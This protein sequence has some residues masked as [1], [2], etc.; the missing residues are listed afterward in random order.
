MSHPPRL[1]PS[2][3]VSPR[4]RVARDPAGTLWVQLIRWDPRAVEAL[5]A[6]PGRRWHPDH[7]AWS[8][9]PPPS[10]PAA[11]SALAVSP[12]LEV[13]RRAFPEIPADPS[14]IALVMVGEATASWGSDSVTGAEAAAEPAAGEETQSPGPFPT[15]VE[16]AQRHANPEDEWLVNPK[17]HPDGGLESL[18]L[19]ERREEENARVLER[20]EEELLLAGY[21]GRTRKNYLGYIRRFGEWSP[22]PLYQTGAEEVRDYLLYLVG[23]RRVSRSVRGQALGALRFLTRKVLGRPSELDLIPMPRRSRQLPAVL[24]RE[25][26]EALIRA[27]RHPT[28]EALVMLLYSAGLRV[29]ELIRLRPED[30]EPERGLI[31]VRRAKGRKDRYTLRSDR[32]LG[33]ARRHWKLQPA[34]PWLFKGARPEA[35]ITARTVQKTVRAMARKAGIER[36]VTPHVLRHSFATHL[37]EAGTDLRYIQMLLGHASTRTTEIYTHVSQ[38]DLGRIRSPLD[39]LPE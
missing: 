10:T 12:S 6:I 16:E 11:P 37:L 4:L 2:A 3:R 24:S 15:P 26:V 25:E 29:G 36:K 38:R 23:H 32:A 34:S 19:R 27:A 18:R 22:M 33:A 35:H 9:P 14:R 28:R 30:L 13:L 17:D 1:P 5:K 20:A 21:S 39:Q 8:L 7:K 31:R